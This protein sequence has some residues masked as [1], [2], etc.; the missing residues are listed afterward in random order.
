M[1]PVLNLALA[2][3]TVLGNVLLQAGDGHCHAIRQ[4]ALH[5]ARK[6]PKPIQIPHVSCLPAANKQIARFKELPFEPSMFGTSYAQRRVGAHCAPVENAEAQSTIK[7]NKKQILYS[8]FVRYHIGLASPG[9][10]IRPT[11]DSGGSRVVVE[12]SP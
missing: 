10:A 11:N 12:S 4:V 9:R 5:S 6:L 8:S 3:A 7:A 1:I 2:L